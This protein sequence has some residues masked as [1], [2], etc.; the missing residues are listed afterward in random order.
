MYIRYKKTVFL[1]LLLSIAVLGYAT[2]LKEQSSAQASVSF[3]SVGQGDAI[4]ITVPHD[5]QIL[6]DGGPGRS[7]LSSLEEHLPF[8]DKTIELIAL[9]HPHADHLRGL[10][11]VLDSYVVKNV[12]LSGAVYESDAYVA[13][14]QRLKDENA[15]VYVARAG[16]AV[17]YQQRPLLR[18]LSPA[19]HLF[20]R[21]VSDVHDSNLVTQLS[22]GEMEF[23]LMGDA[24]E[25]ME[26]ELVARGA[27]GDVTVLKVGHHGSKT[28]TSAELLSAALPEASVIQVGKN[29]YGHP[30]ESVLSRFSALG[31]R[32]LRTDEMG[33]ITWTFNLK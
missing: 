24:E 8:Y 15:H 20:G 31:S 32:V 9:T 33:D 18:V 6:V 23:L 13:F 5:I 12:L 1:A 4:L 19:E 30:H 11:V 3:L 7:I 17:Y 28:S 14:A 26:R 16:D 2:Y 10:N 27:I 29:S 22:L 25:S 21:T